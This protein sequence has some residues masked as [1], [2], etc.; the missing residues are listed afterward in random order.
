M[1]TDKHGSLR[2]VHGLLF[3]PEHKNFESKAHQSDSRYGAIV[4]Q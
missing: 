1:N 3:S 2:A 4:S